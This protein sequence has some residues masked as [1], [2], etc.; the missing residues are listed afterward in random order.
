M[1][2]DA[3]HYPDVGGFTV[4][5]TKKYDS[6]YDKYRGK[7]IKN[8][9]YD[10]ELTYLSPGDHS[11]SLSV[12]PPGASLPDYTIF[13]RNYDNIFYTGALYMGPNRERVDVIYDTGSGEYVCAISSCK[14]CKGQKYD[15]NDEK[16]T[17]YR[18]LPGSDGVHTYGDGTTLKG[19]QVL[20]T[21]CL[22]DDPNSCVKNF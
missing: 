17:T 9:S 20:D 16:K 7:I 15:M 6:K 19:K 13:Q 5:L 4:K 1:D 21:V 8:R 22:L 14:T 3:I 10:P 2:V 18:E 11:G 12:L